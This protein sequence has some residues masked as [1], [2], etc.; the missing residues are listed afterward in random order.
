[1]SRAAVPDIYGGD[2]ETATISAYYPH[3]ADTEKAKSLPDVAPGED[4]GASWLFG[5]H[6]GELSPEGYPGA[7]SCWGSVD[8]RAD[9][10][11]VVM[12]ITEAVIK[13]VEQRVS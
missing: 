3:L 4:M 7:P 1:V 13:H 12:R 2:I 6:A 8:V 10:D 11:D 9:I 5:G